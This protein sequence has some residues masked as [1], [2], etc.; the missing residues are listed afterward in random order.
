MP[1]IKK[2]LI[3]NRGE[4]ALRIMRTCEK[5]DIVPI[6]VYTAVDANSLHVER[7]RKWE[8]TQR[9]L[10]KKN[11][12]HVVD[13]QNVFEITD[14]TSIEE[15]IQVCDQAGADGVHPGYGFLS[16]NPVFARRVVKAG[17]VWVG[18]GAELLEGFGMKDMARAMA[19]EAGL[20]LCE[21]EEG[22][23]VVL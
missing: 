3:A 7:A 18:P 20:P 21:V 15:L 17:L 12:Q 5:L 13:Q 6:V 8:E 14:Y 16:E 2:L 1:S 22:L 10:K 19:E 4:C 11:H 23:L 9:N